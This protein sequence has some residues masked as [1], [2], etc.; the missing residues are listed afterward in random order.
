MA[1]TFLSAFKHPTAPISAWI[2]ALPTHV[3]LPWLYWDEA[4]IM[5]L[6]D[7]DTIAEAHHLQTIFHHALQASLIIYSILITLFSLSK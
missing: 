4:S 1:G 3:P 7:A 2:D 6:Q 5:E